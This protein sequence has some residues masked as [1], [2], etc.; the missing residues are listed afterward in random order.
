MT[1]VMTIKT[2]RCIK[3]KKPFIVAKSIIWFILKN[4]E[5]TGELRDIKRP[6]DN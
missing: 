5:D 4:K 6:E 1:V 3:D 2:D